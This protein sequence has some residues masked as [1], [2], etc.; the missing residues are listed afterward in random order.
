MIFFVNGMQTNI[1]LETEKTVGDVL[2]AFEVECEKNNATIIGVSINDKKIPADL[3]DE[4]FKTSLE[5]TEK[6]EVS[7]VAAKDLQL[8][9]KEIAEQSNVLAEKMRSVPM[10]LQSGKD[11][12]AA[13]TLSEF[14]DFFDCFCRTVTLSALFPAIF[15]NLKVGNETVYRFLDIC[16][17]LLIDLQNA[18]EQKD[19]VMTGDLAEYE[20]APRLADISCMAN[21]AAKIEILDP[22]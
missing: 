11:S 7:T 12:E 10:E 19:S 20:F 14:A 3:L 4:Q 17:P 21:T 8:A 16:A 13:K 1:T 2:N 15:S 6:I 22:Q 18:M 9:F 5:V